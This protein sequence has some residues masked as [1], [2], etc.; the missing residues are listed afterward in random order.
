MKIQTNDSSYENTYYLGDMN[1]DEIEVIQRYDSASKALS[2]FGVRPFLTEEV[3]NENQF[4]DTIVDYSMSYAFEGKEY[5]SEIQTAMQYS[6]L[7]AALILTISLPQYLD[8]A[9][10]TDG[11]L[12]TIYSFFVGFSAIFHIMTIIFCTIFSGSLNMAYNGVDALVIRV[13]RNDAFVLI[14]ILNYFAD[15]AI[16]L[17]MMIAG[18][19]REYLD[20][21][22]QLYAIPVVIFIIFFFVK[23]HFLA[24]K[25][26]NVRSM[27]FYK[28]YCSPDGSLRPDVLEFIYTKK[29]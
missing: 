8:P 15:T 1:L 28:K 24:C 6:V 9:V 12:G 21:Y 20:G 11:S 22:L 23:F 26:Q 2:Y 10:T 5:I 4:Q 17:A 3:K 13:K 18:F 7:Q 19:D 16:L 14:Q 29:E 27:M 25:I